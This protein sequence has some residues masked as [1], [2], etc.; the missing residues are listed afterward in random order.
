MSENKINIAVIGATGYTGLDLVFFLTKH[1]KVNIKYLCATKSLGKKISSF[2]KRLKKKLPK[3]SSVNKIIWSEIDLAFLSLPNGEAQKLIRKIYYKHQ[4]VKFIDLSADFRIKNP[5]IYKKNYKQ[6]HKAKK[7]I[8]KSIYSISEFVKK[9]IQKFRIIANPG[10]YPTSIQIPLVPL[11][12]RKLINIENFTIDSKSGYSGAG[13]N[14]EDKFKHKNLY[15]STFAYS[16]KNHRHI[17]EIDQELKKLSKKNI[18]YSF[19]PHIS[20]TFRGI[21]TSIYVNLE[22]N[23]SLKKLNNELIKYYKK[24]KFIKILKINSELGSGNVLNTNNCEISI[25]ETRIKN[26]ILILCAIDNLVKGASGQ[27]IQNMNL[28]Y[29]FAETQGLK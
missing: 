2:D 11:I 21:L 26:K 18:R 5:N 12:K 22:K 8:K 20:P 7:L 29:G 3:I 4:N 14:F 9:D 10:C 28:V 13:K 19:N 27:A 23:I 16:T 24:D 17:I 6:I 15:H 1:P 25:C